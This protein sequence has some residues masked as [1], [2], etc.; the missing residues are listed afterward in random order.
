MDVKVT[1]SFDK[2]VID[3]AKSFAE[4]NNISLS[5]LTEYLYN[6]I[7]SKNYKSLEDLPVSD[8]VDFVAEG[9]VEYKRVQNRKDQKDEFFSSKK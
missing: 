4:E 8:W 5:R 3:R 7:T 6:Q 2:D 9:R 1:L